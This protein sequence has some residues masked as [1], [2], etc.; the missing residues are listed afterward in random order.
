MPG[1]RSC[2]GKWP[3]ATGIGDIDYSDDCYGED[4]CDDI[5]NDDFSRR[6]EQ[7]L[8]QA[9]AALDAANALTQGY[10]D[11]LEN[12]TTLRDELCDDIPALEADYLYK[13]DLFEDASIHLDPAEAAVTAA[14]DEV[15][16]QEA[17][18]AA[19]QVLVDAAKEARDLAVIAEEVIVVA[20]EAFLA[21]IVKSN[22]SFSF[23]LTCACTYNCANAKLDPPPVLSKL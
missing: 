13:R 20:P 15:G 11:A 5:E 6:N 18:V 12:S 21:M 3:G 7:L 1:Q 22:S 8:L 2:G 16:V 9:E 14:E 17:A 19:A 23:S 4:D 10:I